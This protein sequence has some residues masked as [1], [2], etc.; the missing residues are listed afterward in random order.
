MSEKENSSLLQGGA[1]NHTSQD[2]GHLKDKSAEELLVELEAKLDGM[3]DLDYD[4]EV[5]DAYL[6]ALEEKVPPDHDLDVERSWNEFRAKHADKF[7][8]A[9]TPKK[10]KP[11]KVRLRRMIPRVI[12]VAAVVIVLSM[13]FAQAAGFNFFGV[14][15]RWTEEVF[16]FL[17]ADGRANGEGSVSEATDFNSETYL[18]IK[19]VLAGCGITEDLAPRW[20]PEGF[21]A[22]PPEVQS[23]D[24]GDII[25]CHFAD[26]KD[27]YLVIEIAQYS[28]PSYISVRSF[29]KEDTS[30]E[31]YISNER[32]FYI[33]PNIESVTATWSDGEALMINILGNIPVDAMK[34]ILDSIGG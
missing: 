26:K 24:I 14:I 21:E 28:D 5:I 8:A 16:S 2:Y 12:A 19:S 18:N 32:L 15:G 29:E 11:Q 1:E 27:G 6:A 13:V 3:T 34:T 7:E 4:G 9:G 31:E 10:E 17:S 20:Y 30:T 22:V 23:S 33:F 25:Y